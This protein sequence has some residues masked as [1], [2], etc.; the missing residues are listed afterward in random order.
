MAT[1][2]KFFEKVVQ[3]HAPPRLVFEKNLVRHG[4]GFGERG[5]VGSEEACGPSDLILNVKRELCEWDHEQLTTKLDRLLPLLTL[6]RRFQDA[7]VGGQEVG[8]N[9]V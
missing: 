3:Q 8:K 7:P 6:F 1:A 5:W 4:C 2:G 9:Q